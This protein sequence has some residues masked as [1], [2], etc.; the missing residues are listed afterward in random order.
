MRLLVV[1]GESPGRQAPARL[2]D[3]NR[4][5]G[6]VSSRHGSGRTFDHG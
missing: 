1:D 6:A 2:L 4:A 3:L 5:S